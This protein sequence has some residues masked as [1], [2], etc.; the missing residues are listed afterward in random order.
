LEAQAIDFDQGGS[1][2]DSMST[3]TAILEPLS[4]GTLRLPGTWSP[5]RFR[6]RVEPLDEV[7]VL[8]EHSVV[9]LKH[10]LSSE[11]LTKGARGTIVHVYEGGAGYEVEFGTTGHRPKLVTVEP[12]D[13][14]LA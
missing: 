11:G 3:I 2:D 13:I 9:S 6:V 7:A 12:S 10:D 5:G 8:A 1:Y 14:E 4:D